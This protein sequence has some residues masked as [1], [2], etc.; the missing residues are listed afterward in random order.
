M[1]RKVLGM[2]LAAMQTETLTYKDLAN[3]KIE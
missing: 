3:H 1:K 2:V